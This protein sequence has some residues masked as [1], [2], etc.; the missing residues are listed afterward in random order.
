MPAASL[1]V[2][3][4]KGASLAVE[5]GPAVRLRY[6]RFD[7]SFSFRSQFVPVPA[8]GRYRRR[9]PGGLTFDMGR[10][11]GGAARGSLAT[12]SDSFETNLSSTPVRWAYGEG[13][14]LKSATA[15]FTFRVSGCPT[16]T[17]QLSCSQPKSL[18]AF[19]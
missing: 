2:A 11:T 7:L 16:A 12:H 14:C 13:P 10:A 17:A 6:G 15:R 4:K 3:A 1:S 19:S 8:T 5:K 9:R 18:G